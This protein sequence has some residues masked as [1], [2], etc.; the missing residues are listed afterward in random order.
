VVLTVDPQRA[1]LQQQATVNWK[2][3]DE[4]KMENETVGD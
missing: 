4:W 2:S 1:G 3:N